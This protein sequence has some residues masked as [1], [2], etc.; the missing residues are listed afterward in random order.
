MFR[1]KAAVTITCNTIVRSLGASSGQFKKQSVFI[2][3]C[4][5]RLKLFGGVREGPKGRP[6]LL[7]GR[8]PVYGTIQRRSLF[9]CHL[10]CT[11]AH[12]TASVTAENELDD[13]ISRWSSLKIHLLTPDAFVLC[14][15]IL[16]SFFFFLLDLSLHYSVSFI[17][18]EV[19]SSELNFIGLFCER[20]KNKLV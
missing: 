6:S 2:E 7:Y 18:I 1:N 11:L 10:S 14:I 20:N 15:L 12:R 9:I 13:R 8:R 5:S 16:F 19:L 3:G 4:K 17:S